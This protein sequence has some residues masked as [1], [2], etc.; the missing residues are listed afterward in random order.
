M[1]HLFYYIVF[2]SFSICQSQNSKIKVTKLDSIAFDADSFVGLDGFRNCYYIKDNVFFKKA[3]TLSLQYQ[4]LAL[5]K[6]TK[7]DSTNPL[8]I[9][10]F[11]EEFNSV[12][13]L[14]NQLNEIQKIEFSK[15]ETPIV[16]SAIGISAQNQLWVYNSLNQ[17]IGLYDL[18][19]NTYKNLGV[20]IKE[21]FSYYQTDF[22]Y[23]H[24][25]DSKNQWLTATIFGRIINNG[26][27][28]IK[29]NLQFLDLSEVLFLK[30]KKLFI[31]DR[32]GNKLYE[33]EIVEKSI[34]NFY[35][36]DQILSIFTDHGITNYKI[37]LP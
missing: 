7:V 26:L 13:V 32:N 17:Q 27:I 23:F 30:D 12:V 37:I 21:T 22:N 1:K 24:W 10:L 25:I 4:N 19:S 3:D 5:G 34:K 28:E 36:K 31:R 16:A 33:I 15:L 8:K 20:P 18:N 29:E 2:L 9:I 14:D 11:Y 35:Y 6:L